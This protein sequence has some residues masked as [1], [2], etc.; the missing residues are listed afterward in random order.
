MEGQLMLKFIFNKGKP[1]IKVE[2]DITFNIKKAYGSYK[3]LKII[4]YFDYNK[5][6]N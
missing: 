6:L 2:P 3:S 5:C 1:E 4:F